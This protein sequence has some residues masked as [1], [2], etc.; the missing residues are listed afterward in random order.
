MGMLKS[1]IGK[2]FLPIALLSLLCLTSGCRQNTWKLWDSY[3]ARFID[4]QGRVFDPNGDQH[5]TSEGQA[6]ALFFA[7]ADNDQAHFEHLL[8]WT[9]TNLAQGNLQEH[10]P[11]WLWGKDQD[12]KWR[13]LDTNSASDA[14]VWMA[15]T[16]IEAGRLWDS[17]KYTNIGLSMMSEIAKSEVVDLPGFGPML[18]PGPIGF[19]HDQT[20]GKQTW[21]LNPSYLPIFIFNRFAAEDPSGPWRQIADNTPRLLAQSSRHGFV[22]DWVDYFPGDGFYPSSIQKPGVAE[23]S[24]RGGSYDAIR[25]YLWAGMMDSDRGKRGEIINSIPGISAY[26]ADH[27]APPEKVSDLGVPL[28]QDGPVGFSAAVLPYLRAF[29]GSSKISTRQIIRMNLMRDTT[30][31]LYGKDLSYYDQNLAL[32]ATGFLEGRF[33]FGPGGELK[34]EWKGK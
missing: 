1:P 25:V 8:T 23:S 12:G 4:Y 20:Q 9:Q 5:T 24:D 27:D 11:A 26:L 33:S 34:V 15:F 19:Q 28:E 21:T 2:R 16:L 6:Y 31:G 3:A 13:P 14:D 17:P 29:S 7:L 30:T 10:L 18:I 32:F 22:I